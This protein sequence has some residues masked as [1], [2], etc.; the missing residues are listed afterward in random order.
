[1][2]ESD[3]V[4]HLPS[5]AG[6]GKADRNREQQTDS[7]DDEENPVECWSRNID[8]FNAEE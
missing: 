6:E 3:F 7:T 1:M 2:A 5:E 8:S 4:M